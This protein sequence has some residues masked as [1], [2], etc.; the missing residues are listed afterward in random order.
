MG[1]DSGPY[2]VIAPV[3]DLVTADY[4]H[5]RWLSEIESRALALG[6]RGRSVLDVACG[7]GASF[8]PLMERGYSVTGCD[9][10]RGM[11]AVAACKAPDVTLLEAD[12]RT[13]SRLGQFDLVL[14]LDDGLNHLLEHDELCD[15]LRGM[16]R[17]LASG[18]IAVWDVNTVAMYRSALAEPRVVST[19]DPFVTW[20][21][22]VP[23]RF[24]AGGGAEVVTHTFASTVEGAWQRRT[25]VVTQRH[26]SDEDVH[27]AAA[28]AGLDI[29]ATFGQSP[30]AILDGRPDAAIHTK[31]LYFATGPSDARSWEGVE[32]VSE[33]WRP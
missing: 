6:L 8:L 12:M 32:H 17:N 30:G 3:Y 20:E 2:D 9:N 13:L 15:T 14:C 22:R 4:D 24:S 29:L 26:W 23:D 33:Y 11:L 16:R 1:V 28:R 10:S 31:F 21:S 25:A 19:G 7:T 18:G 27:R 5:G